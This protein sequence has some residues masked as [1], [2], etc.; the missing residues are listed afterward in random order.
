[1]SIERR[2]SGGFV[3]YLNDEEIDT[4]FFTDYSRE[5]ARKSLIDHDGYDPGILVCPPR[6]GVLPLRGRDLE[7]VLED[8]TADVTI[9]QEID[10]TWMFLGVDGDGDTRHGRGYTTKE[11]AQQA[12]AEVLGLDDAG[13]D[14][15]EAE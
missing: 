2:Y 14:E 9:I 6:K 12:A 15:D 11:K 5:E 1:M 10:T 13:L 3:V 8:N 7:S 4:V